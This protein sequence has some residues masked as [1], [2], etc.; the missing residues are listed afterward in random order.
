[1]KN[2]RLLLS[3]IWLMLLPVIAF[4]STVSSNGAF[5][6]WDPSWDDFYYPIIDQY[7]LVNNEY[8]AFLNCPNTP[9]CDTI[10]S[11]SPSSNLQEWFVHLNGE[12]TKEELVDL[13]FKRPVEWLLG[14]EGFEK[15]DDDLGKRF[16]KP[17]YHFFK[18]YLILAKQTQNTSSDSSSGIGWYQGESYDYEYQ[19]RS[20]DKRELLSRA[21]ELVAMA[22]D[23]FM[24]NRAGFQAVKMAH[25]L[26]ENEAAIRYFNTIL[27]KESSNNYI[28]Y[29]AM[30]EMAGAAYNENLQTLA[31]NSYL[32]VYKQLPDRRN[33]CAISL[34]FL[35]WELLENNKE[36]LTA[37][38]NSDIKSFFKTFHGRGDA[39]REM[40]HIAEFNVNS[41]YLEVL[42]VR[43]LDQMQA[44]IFE[45]NAYGYYEDA[46]ID[47][48]YPKKLQLF[49]KGLLNNTKLKNKD[50]WSLVVTTTHLY[51]KENTTALN[52]ITTLNPQQKNLKHFKRL[53]E[54]VVFMDIKYLDR[55]RINQ[56]YERISSDV[57]LKTHQPTVAAFFN[58]ISALYK[59]A[60]NPIV[61][62][63]ASINYDAYSNKD[64]YDWNMVGKFHG[65]SWEY[66]SKYF[67]LNEQYINSFDAF[68]SLKNPTLFEKTILKRMKT[69]P[70]DYVHDLR[71]TYYL[72]T[73]QLEKAMQEFIKVKT[74][75]VFWEKGL[76]TELFSASIKEWMN[77]PFAD[78]SNDFHIKYEE[79][80]GE[81]VIIADSSMEREAYR[82]NK[83]KLTEVL[84]RLKQLAERDKNNTADY[85]YM[86][87]NAWYNM[88]HLG[89]FMNN[90]FYITNDQRNSVIGSKYG[91][92]ELTIE[93]DHSFILEQANA[94]LLK[95]LASEKGS[96]ET[97]AAIL[98]M[99]AK[100]NSCVNEGYNSDT[101]NVT[102]QL[103][104]DHQEYFDLL[105]Q[106]YLDT[107]YAQN[108]LKECSWFSNYVRYKN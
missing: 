19:Q 30:E 24:K 78:I 97:N 95:G 88:S 25:Y 77:I 29:R 12:F 55:I 42:A 81:N 67:Y 73:D 32:E 41:A 79:V 108:V 71:G 39:I 9:F 26:Q 56:S 40:E 4:G 62:V 60:N 10:S 102:F 52:Y 6:G 72:R 93:S 75:E 101:N 23:D 76:R 69:A 35:N 51:L 13:I 44:A 7:S 106:E 34:R 83:I 74:P 63:L 103:C 104:D 66:N 70:K 11:D 105:E 82:D 50:L 90:S 84:T 92:V 96:K 21:L 17:K 80:L 16:N 14:E 86:M 28:Y 8:H 37:Q 43:Y 2:F 99:L 18:E 47:E 54:A 1:M 15:Y 27:K 65:D 68:V 107:E 98:F 46:E 3:R 49:A 20:V 58:H 94:Y 85:Y 48:K 91:D 38:K 5:C 33:T 87:G 61:S 36:F 53:K 45:H 22:P 31:A 64:S 57:D 59:E 100:T 89:W